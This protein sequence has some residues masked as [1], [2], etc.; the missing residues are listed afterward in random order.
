MLLNLD[1]Y[2]NH[3][4]EDC[5]TY[6]W[7]IEIDLIK[8][9][10]QLAKENN[11]RKGILVRYILDWSCEKFKSDKEYRE[12]MIKISMK[13]NNGRA[14]IIRS[15][16]ISK[17]VQEKFSELREEYRLCNVSYFMNESIRKFFYEME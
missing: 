6:Y 10:E 3:K 14:K 1:D 8:K 11:V 9:L 13:V 2:K 12:H 16:S 4:K 5:T 7:R 17:D 15:Y